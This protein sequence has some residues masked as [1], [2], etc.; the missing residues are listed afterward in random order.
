MK[1]LITIALSHQNAGEID[2]FSLQAT[3]TKSKAEDNKGKGG[4]ES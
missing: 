3:K 4:L 1:K 2:K